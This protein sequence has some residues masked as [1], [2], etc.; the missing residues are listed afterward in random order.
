MHYY[1]PEQFKPPADI[2]A[3]CAKVQVNGDKHSLS[4]ARRWAR[5]QDLSLIWIESLDMSDLSSWQGPDN[6]LTF[7]F[8]QKEDATLFQLRW[9]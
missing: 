7:Y 9:A 5:K 8:T 6:L 4:D 2:L 1:D 3:Q